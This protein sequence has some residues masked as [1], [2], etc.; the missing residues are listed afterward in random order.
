M[1]RFSNK[2]VLV[3]GGTSGI[4]LA[5]ARRIAG[6]GGLVAVTGVT[7]EHIENAGEQL[8]QEALVLKN[9]AS[10]P[11]EAER[12]A[13]ILAE[14]FGSLDGLFLNAGYG[15]ASPI[16]TTGAA[17]F[18]HMNNVNVRGP[19]LQM[20]ALRSLLNAGSSIVLTASIGAHLGA[21]TGGVYAATKAAVSA[22][23]RCWAAE[24][25]PENIRVNSIGP[26]PID[27]NFFA[28]TGRTPEQI[29]TTRDAFTRM[30]ALKRFGTAGEAAAVAC[31]L[32]SDDAS[33]VTGSQYMVDGGLSYR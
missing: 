29:E 27:T 2:K 28:A 5:A 20:A 25:A 9:D 12:L 7:E 1:S 30:V 31:F 13:K 14:K 24:L 4:G 6:E 8:P 26:G 21:A 17:Q 32:L 10:L 18:D 23:A 3:T 19:V 16:V 15:G 33:Y 22:L 11:E